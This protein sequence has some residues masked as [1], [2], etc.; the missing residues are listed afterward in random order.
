ML[1]FLDSC[2]HLNSSGNGLTPKEDAI[3][4]TVGQGNV[5]SSGGRFGGGSM[6][7][8]FNHTLTLDVDALGQEHII[9]GQSAKFSAFNQTIARVD[10]RAMSLSDPASGE[11]LFPFIRWS[12]LSDGTMALTAQGWKD[13]GGGGFTTSST[14]TSP[15]MLWGQNGLRVTEWY[16]FEMKID[17][18]GSSGAM[19]VTCRVN[20]QEM[21][22][23]G[24]QE[25]GK[26]LLAGDP[27][28]ASC[29][30]ALNANVNDVVI[31]DDYADSA[32]S[33]I[34]FLGDVRVDCI[35]PRA[36]GSNSG[37]TPLSGTNYQMV[38]EHANDRDTTTIS[39]AS[40]GEVDTYLYDSVA[41]L[42]LGQIYGLQLNMLAK[43]DDA[44][45]VEISAAIIPNGGALTIDSEAHSVNGSY[46]DYR[47]IWERL[48]GATAL[49]TAAEID[50]SEFGVKRL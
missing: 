36:A 20:E 16:Y 19:T 45:A 47:K 4:Y 39:A 2:K 30:F 49:P 14:V 42:G 44:T 21:I 23:W 35:W 41:S 32:D 13:N 50:N 7:G 12:V 5:S 48:P 43:K 31:S 8:L 1:R 26:D 17:W 10:F 28:F 37:W 22:V 40:G 6:S 34:D 25:G 27:H 38:D 29:A 3:K 24:P 11:V 18:S 33:T 15:S 46:I 9:V